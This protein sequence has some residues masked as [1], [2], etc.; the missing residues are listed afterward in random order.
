MRASVL[1][2]SG[3]DCTPELQGNAR[4]TISVGNGNGTFYPC[5]VSSNLH[6]AC[7]PGYPQQI[8]ELERGE[9]GLLL[10]STSEKD[11]A[12]I[13][14][15]SERYNNMVSPRSGPARGDKTCVLTSGRGAITC[16]STAQI[17]A[18]L[19]GARTTEYEITETSMTAILGTNTGEAAN[20]WSTLGY[21]YCRNI[22]N[23]PYS[24][25]RIHF[26]P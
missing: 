26:L 3:P 13:D 20:C 4:V 15:T 6:L 18:G 16:F 9:A 23:P 8:F 21:T 2:A 5:A 7:K 22:V 14:P 10:H 19:Y 17:E 25:Y 11:L 1:E 12:A 24:V